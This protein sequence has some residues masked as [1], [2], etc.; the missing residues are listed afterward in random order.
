[1]IKPKTFSADYAD[2]RGYGGVICILI[3]EHPRNSREN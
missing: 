3:R 1:M 2:E